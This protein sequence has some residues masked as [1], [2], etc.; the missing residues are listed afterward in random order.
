MDKRPMTAG[1]IA[2]RLTAKK[3]EPLVR[4]VEQATGTKLR[5][6]APQRSPKADKAGSPTHRN[7]QTIGR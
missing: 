1:E 5:L 3:I 7:S 2:G 4:Y 6:E